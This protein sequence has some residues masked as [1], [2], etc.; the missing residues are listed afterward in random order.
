[1]V[2]VQVISKILNSKDYSIV[3][4]NLLTTEHF[5]GYEKEFDFIK[6]HFD[7]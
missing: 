6:E 5:V 7:T 3:E 2:Q 1:M 4:D